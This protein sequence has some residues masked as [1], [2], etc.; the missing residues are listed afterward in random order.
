[1][2]KKK[3][4]T[5][6]GSFSHF[7]IF[8]FCTYLYHFII[9]FSGKTLV[10]ELLL[11]KRVLETGRKGIY[12]LPFVSVAREK[13]YYLQVGVFFFFPPSIFNSCIDFFFFLL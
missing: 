1:M 9:L 5:S 12:I 3:N 4:I 8:S 2:K 6:S 7:I 11:L 13:M 10:A